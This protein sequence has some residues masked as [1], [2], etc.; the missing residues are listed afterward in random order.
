MSFFLKF[1]RNLALLLVVGIVLYL[2]YPDIMRQVYDLLGALFG[3]LIL[4]ILIV[5]ALPR[6]RRRRSRN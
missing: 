1:L 5:A 6:G 2:I 4:L 3:P